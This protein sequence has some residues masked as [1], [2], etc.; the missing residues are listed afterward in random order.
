MKSI[1]IQINGGIGK[2]IAFTALT[3]FLAEKYKNIYIFSTKPEIFKENPYIQK[4]NPD[5]DNSFFRKLVKKDDTKIIFSDPYN[6]EDFIKKKKH[7]LNVWAEMCELENINGYNLITKLYNSEEEN[8]IANKTLQNLKEITNDKF[9]LFQ[10]SGGKDINNK[11]NIYEE[12]IKR[13][14][15]LNYYLE[16]INKLNKKYPNYKLIRY[17]LLN[18]QIPMELKEKVLTIYPYIS[19]KIYKNIAEKAFK[20][21]SIDSSLHHITCGIKK[22][23]VIWGETSPKHFGYSFHTNI[24]IQKKE[25]QPYFKILGLDKETEIAFPEPE[26]VL[27]KI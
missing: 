16:L 19:F 3:P 21:I 25:T 4:V 24:R 9:I 5:T 15:P 12:K 2:Q 17:G 1:L 10:L 7:L 23:T 8:K 20:V 22:T 14:Y 13:S 6:N 11:R 26:E 18:E 27:E